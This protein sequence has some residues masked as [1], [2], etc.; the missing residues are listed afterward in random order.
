MSRSKSKERKGRKYASTKKWVEKQSS[1]FT[2]TY[3]RLPKG[4]SLYQPKAGSALLDILPYEVAKGSE[5]A[6]GN[7]HAEKGL[8]YWERTFHVHRNIGPNSEAFVCLAK[9]LK[10]KCPV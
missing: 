8:L 4:T 10:K 6:G 5:V 7:P 1:G 3:L 9:T 2:S